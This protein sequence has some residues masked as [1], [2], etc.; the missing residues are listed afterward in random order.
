MNYQEHKARMQGR[1]RSN[2]TMED[3]RAMKDR[4]ENM[5]Q[6]K[7][8]VIKDL[9]P[10]LKKAL[11][12]TKIVLPVRTNQGAPLACFFNVLD[13]YIEGAE[14]IEGFELIQNDSE[15]TLN[16]HCILRL[17]DGTYVDPTPAVTDFTPYFACVKEDLVGDM[18]IQSPMSY[19]FIKKAKVI[20]VKLTN[21]V[22]IEDYI[23][24]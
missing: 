10:N 14:I 16:R 21:G 15:I 4:L 11:N 12:I 13:Y 8:R 23:V 20:D 19:F 6:Q 24:A 5:N 22:V 18:S 9:Q 17:P 2:Y 7:F 3:V 1:S